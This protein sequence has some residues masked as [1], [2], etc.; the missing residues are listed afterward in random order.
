[1]GLAVKLNWEYRFFDVKAA[2]LHGDLKEKVYLALPPK[3][4]CE[5]G[6]ENVFKF[7]KSMYGLL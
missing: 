7:N 1:M 2:Y 6:E 3:F 4:E 5:Y